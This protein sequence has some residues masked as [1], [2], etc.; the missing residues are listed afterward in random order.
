MERRY[1]LGGAFQY[2]VVMELRYKT[3]TRVPRIGMGR[4]LRMSSKEIIF[5]TDQ[6]LE[7]GTKLEISIVWPALLDR[8]VPL[9]LVVEGNVV[10]RQGSELTARIVRHHFR[11]R[12]VQSFSQIPLPV[13]V[14]AQQGLPASHQRQQ[15]V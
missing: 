4:T 14:A 10:G 3:R 9:Q 2:P 8:V 5:T 13:M 11:T 6:P 15:A 12:R 7:E 1:T